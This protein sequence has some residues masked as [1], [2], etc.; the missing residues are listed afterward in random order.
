MPA[1]EFIKENVDSNATEDDLAC[2]EDVLNDLTV[3]V[4][5]DSRL[6]E[7][8]NNNSM[9]ALVAYS[10][11]NDIDLEKWFVNFFERNNEYI[12]D[13]KEN[14]FYMINDLNDYIH[15]DVVA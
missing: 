11:V 12:S 6:L 2:Y 15:K 7:V 8:E 10:F 13:Q 5:N 1:L 4:N 9:L 3:E 14:Y